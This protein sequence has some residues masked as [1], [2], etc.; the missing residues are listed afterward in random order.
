MKKLFLS[1]VAVYLMILPSLFAQPIKLEM[2]HALEGF[3][4]EKLKE[5]VD[6]FNASQKDYEVHLTRKG[7]YTETY[8]EGVKARKTN[9]SP[10]HIL[11]V[12]EVATPTFMREKSLYI[13]AHDLLKK[14]GYGVLEGLIPAIID[15]YSDENSQ[16]L[17]LPFNI[18]TGVLYYNED[19][20]KK[21]DLSGPPQTWEEVESYA[22]KL[23]DA[24]Y[25]CALTTAWPSGYLLEHF[26][27]RHNV[28]FATKENG[29]EG[30]DVRLLVNSD[31]FIFNL[32]KFAQWQKEGIFKYAGRS[33][34]EA[35]SLF[36]SGQCAMILQS[37][38]RLVV[39]QKPAKFKI[40]VGPLPYW[41][42][43]TKNPHNLVTGGAALWAIK[44][45]N[46]KEEKGM[47]EFFNFIAQ[48]EQQ[49][50][51]ATATG[52]MPISKVS[53]QLLK[54]AGYYAKN[55]QAHIGIESLMLPQTPYS[56]G[57]HISGFVDIREDLIDALTEVFIDQKPVKAIFDGAV[58][59]GNALIQK[60]KGEEL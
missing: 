53:Y 28:P 23:K 44:G 1:F 22:Q 2:W 13:S 49:K 26:G 58:E 33:V 55:P 20:F 57:I 11:Q 32:T 37:S 35:E 46:E 8:Q 50:E 30:Q 4:E 51:W 59:K 43:L 40:G 3:M 31:P 21:A 39:L 16:L 34:P 52:Y 14:N 42:S 9:S 54:E 29:F 18:S 5:L 41:A 25:L 45:H 7:N 36:T 12:Y 47:A 17:G 24:G 27:A 38:N 19:A 60:E 56:K 10:P 6:K 48:P 15:F